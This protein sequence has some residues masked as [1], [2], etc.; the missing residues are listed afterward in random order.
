MK[1]VTIV[2]LLI[3]VTAAVAAESSCPACVVDVS[4]DE[5]CGCALNS[6]HSVSLENGQ[7]FHCCSDIEINEKG[8]WGDVWGGIKSGLK[9]GSLT[10]DIPFSGFGR[11]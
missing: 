6:K 5:H 11:K 3:A 8:F 7:S 2:F 1:A 10:V 9:G 4:A